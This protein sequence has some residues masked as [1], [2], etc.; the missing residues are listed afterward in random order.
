MKKK[1]N[2][3]LLHI[4]INEF[5]KELDDD[6]KKSSWYL[7]LSNLNYDLTKEELNNTYEIYQNWCKENYLRIPKRIEFYELTKLFS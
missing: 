4:F 1:S 5:L 3:K 6:N 2:I 7:K